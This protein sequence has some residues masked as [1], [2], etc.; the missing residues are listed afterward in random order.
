MVPF[1]GMQSTAASTVSD[2][3]DE[4]STKWLEQHWMSSKNNAHLRE[5]LEQN[6][7]FNYAASNS[8]KEACNEMSSRFL[9]Q[10]WDGKNIQEGYIADKDELLEFVQILSTFDPTLG[11]LIKST[12]VKSSVL[13]FINIFSTFKTVL[14]EF[15]DSSYDKSDVFTSS[16][17][18]ERFAKPQGM[19]EFLRTHC[20]SSAY[21]FEVKAV[22]W[23]ILAKEELAAGRD[24]DLYASIIHPT[25]PFGCR[26]PT[27]LLSKFA[28]LHFIPRPVKSPNDTGVEAPYLSYEDAKLLLDKGEPNAM[29]NYVPSL[30]ILEPK[31]K[32]VVPPVN[33]KGAEI[34]SST[35]CVVNNILTTI[36]CKNCGKPRPVYVVGGGIKWKEDDRDLVNRF[37]D[38][39]SVTYTCGT[40]FSELASTIDFT[41]N[42]S[43][44]RKID[45]RSYRPFIP[46]Y[47]GNL[48]S[49]IIR[50]PVMFVEIIQIKQ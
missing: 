50:N 26:R 6:V 45:K 37:L 8:I 21:M 9:N 5:R 27:Q 39:Q 15:I 33:S 41:Q 4:S 19:N 3:E 47:V 22:C 7:Y 17:C 46:T 23:Q 43:E 28:A 38:D 20:S 1:H 18:K 49:I 32:W 12:E 35:L 30:T 2:V 36:R 13:N 14:G 24:P 42:S 29:D 40:D 25:C 16:R 34:Q 10:V 11:K 31:V 48:A 44:K